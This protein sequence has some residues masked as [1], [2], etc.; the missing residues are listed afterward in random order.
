MPQIC[1]ALLLYL[2]CRLKSITHTR[3]FFKEYIA[4]L[5]EKYK[6]YKRKNRF[7]TSAFS[8]FYFASV[9]LLFRFY[10]ALFLLHFCGLLFLYKFLTFAVIYT[11]F[12]YKFL[13][14]MQSSIYTSFAHGASITNIT[15][16]TNNTNMNERM[17]KSGCFRNR[18]FHGK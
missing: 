8:F 13:T 5:K 10:F 11:C 1:A 2:S 12:L 18:L 15:N 14:F 3:F 6:K 7:C 16:I 4:D 17:K 9:S